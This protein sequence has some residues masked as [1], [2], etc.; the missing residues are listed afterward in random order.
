MGAGKP[1]SN[2]GPSTPRAT[3]G[4]TTRSLTLALVSSC[5]RPVPGRALGLRRCGSLLLLLLLLLLQEHLLLEGRLVTSPLLP[6]LACQGSSI[7]TSRPAATI[8]KACRQRT[9][10]SEVGLLSVR[11]EACITQYQAVRLLTWLAI[12]HGP[13]HMH[14]AS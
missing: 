9:S 11:Q 3:L 5:A 4:T 2:S 12:A 14:H 8:A 7:P 6:I 13:L 1:Q 10:G